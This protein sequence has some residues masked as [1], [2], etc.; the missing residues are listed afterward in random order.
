MSDSEYLHQLLTKDAP[1]PP[2]PLSKSVEELQEILDNADNAPWDPYDPG[3]GTVRIYAN[4]WEDDEGETPEAVSILHVVPSVS[5]I[6][7]GAYMNKE[8]GV[9]ASLAPEVTADYIRIVTGL[10]GWR[11]NILSQAQRCRDNGDDYLAHVH[12]AVANGI[13]TI[14]NRG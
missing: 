14:L 5:E 6:D 10:E 9:L 8:N 4:A 7:T 13:R 12:E 3:D 1:P 11:D 2:P